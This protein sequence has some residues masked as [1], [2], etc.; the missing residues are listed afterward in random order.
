MIR[1]I[2]DESN[3]I[4]D[5]KINNIHSNFNKSNSI[6]NI[7]INI[8][9]NQKNI[10]NNINPNISIRAKNKSAI[11]D[12]IFDLSLIEKDKNRERSQK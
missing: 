4:L 11:L 2:D 10:N 8:N 3:N 5:D 1:L 9:Y 12:S 7:N 6:G